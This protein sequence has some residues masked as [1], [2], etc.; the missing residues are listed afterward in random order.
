M[1]KQAAVPTGR[2]NKNGRPRGGSRGRGGSTA[3]RSQSV[4]SATPESAA[5][6]TGLKLKI[7]L[8]G[9]NT[10]VR[11]SATPQPTADY[12]VGAADEGE[13]V[14]D[15]VEVDQELPVAA[16]DEGVAFTENVAPFSAE[17]F[18]TEGQFGRTTRAGRQT[19]PPKYFEDSYGNSDAIQPGATGVGKVDDGSEEEYQDTTVTR[20]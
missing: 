5:G 6:A 7:N 14:P 12:F 17:A 19:K 13:E 2:R 9:T 10:H 15:Q 3:G 8:N 1:P 4:I 16:V 20:K 18:S 11:E